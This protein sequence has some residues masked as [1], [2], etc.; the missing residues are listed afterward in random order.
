M[1]GIMNIESE[2]SIMKTQTVNI[3]SP[4]DLVK[5][6]GS[7]SMSLRHIAEETEIPF[8]TLRNYRYEK[9]DA[10]AMPYKIVAKLSEFFLSQNYNTIEAL[11]FDLI[12]VDDNEQLLQKFKIKDELLDLYTIHEIMLRYYGNDKVK[13]DDVILYLSSKAYDYLNSNMT[14]IGH[15]GILYLQRA[16]EKGCHIIYPKELSNKLTD[17]KGTKITVKKE[18]NIQLPTNEKN[19]YIIGD[20]T[21]KSS[22]FSVITTP[23]IEYYIEVILGLKTDFIKNLYKDCGIPTEKAI[24]TFLSEKYTL[25]SDKWGY[26]VNKTI[27]N[28]YQEIQEQLLK[29]NIYVN[30]LAG[31]YDTQLEPHH[32]TEPGNSCGPRN[33]LNP[34]QNIRLYDVSDVI[35][36]TSYENIESIK[37]LIRPVDFDWR[38]LIHEYEIK[39]D[40]PIEVVINLE[41]GISVI[42]SIKFFIESGEQV[43]YSL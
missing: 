15:P 34:R 36:K 13:Y 29:T 19:G 4:S 27:L 5:L 40:K 32:Y 38:K 1:C 16:I 20:R 14:I 9:T 10:D 8:P 28:I 22:N 24:I 30:L 17:L 26:N 31:K 21:L 23:N 37:E 25:T 42:Q 33:S 41:L 11:S 35:V 7:T 2:E 12:C 6:L 43:T 3:Y 39:K 18:D